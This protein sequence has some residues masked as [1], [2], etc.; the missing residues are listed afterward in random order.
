MK[1]ECVAKEYVDTVVLFYEDKCGVVV[2]SP[3]L[4]HPIGAHLTCWRPF[5]EGCWKPLTT[6]AKIEI[7]V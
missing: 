3:N 6:G 7:T 1:D 5:S 4:G 2:H